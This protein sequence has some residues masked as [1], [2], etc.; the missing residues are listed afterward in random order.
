M[1][2]EEA[3]NINNLNGTAKRN[4]KKGRKYSTN[5]KLVKQR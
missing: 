3:Q 2:T 4:L 1:K 5:M